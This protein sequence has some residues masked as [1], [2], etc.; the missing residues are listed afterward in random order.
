[1]SAFDVGILS[2]L[3]TRRDDSRRSPELPALIPASGIGTGIGVAEKFLISRHPLATPAFQPPTP[4]R[5]CLGGWK[6]KE[7]RLIRKR[8]EVQETKEMQKAS[9]VYGSEWLGRSAEGLAVDEV[10]VGRL[11][12]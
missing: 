12:S 5:V 2:V 7:W 8:E 4:T 9:G 3:E 10:P 1:M 11:W 6:V